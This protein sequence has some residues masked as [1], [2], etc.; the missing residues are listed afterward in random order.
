M[1]NRVSN[2]SLFGV[3]LICFMWTPVIINRVVGCQT[4]E[5]YYHL[6]FKQFYSRRLLFRICVCLLYSGNPTLLDLS[7]GVPLGWNSI[8]S[9]TRGFIPTFRLSIFPPRFSTTVLTSISVLT[10]SVSSVRHFSTQTDNSEG[11]PSPLKTG[12]P[13]RVTSSKEH[14][15]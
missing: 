12:K 14:C 7:K 9:L 5:R 3:R 15:S 13:T 4:L 6:L 8:L 1:Y 10:T 2:F 11:P